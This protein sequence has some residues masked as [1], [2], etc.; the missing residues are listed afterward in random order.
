MDNTIRVLIKPPQKELKEV[1]INNQL[2][3]LQ[4]WVGG[5]LEMVNITH[6]LVLICNEEGKLH[7]LLPNF[8]F[9]NDIIMGTV[10]FARKEGDKLVSMQDADI[11]F[12][13]KFLAK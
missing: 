10:I 1:I 2:T 11:S 6:Q 9:N 12:V 5:M 7:D 3:E 13:E 8:N 4:S